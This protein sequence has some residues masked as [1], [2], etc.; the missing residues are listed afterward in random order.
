MIRSRINVPILYQIDCYLNLKI[1]T[2]IPISRGGQASEEG[3]REA[4]LRLGGGPLM[5]DPMRWRWA[6]QG[7]VDLGWIE[8]IRTC[9]ALFVWLIIRIFSVSKQYFSLTTNPPTV[10]SVMAYQP[11]EH[12]ASHRGQSQPHQRSNAREDTQVSEG[13]LWRADLISNRLT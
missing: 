5:M 10:L 8:S 9:K 4:N 7:K 12:S 3:A 2:L 13:N 1:E 6:W 11:N